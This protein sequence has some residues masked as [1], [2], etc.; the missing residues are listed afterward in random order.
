M[1]NV[2]F[3]PKF[4]FDNRQHLFNLDLLKKLFYNED[5]QLNL[6][7]NRNER[8]RDVSKGK[9]PGDVWSIPTQPSSDSHYAMWPQALAKRMILCS[10]K[11][12]DIVCDPFCGS[13]TTGK[14]AIE[15]QRK[16]IGI[17]L[18]YSEIQQRK[19]TNVQVG[20]IY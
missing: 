4:I 16:F 19:T 14:V 10:T 7:T 3:L 20:L 8:G 11:A 17:D 2:K 6:D 18:G 13:G 5:K 12:G 15:L 1:R 9:N